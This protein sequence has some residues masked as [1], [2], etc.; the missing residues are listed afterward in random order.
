[1]YNT[2]SSKPSIFAFCPHYG[3]LM[4]MLRG[5]DSVEPEA[6]GLQSTSSIIHRSSTSSLVDLPLG[7]Q[8][9]GQNKSVE[10]PETILFIM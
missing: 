2:I 1:M 5:L 7:T 9:Q 8:R 6:F 3:Q 10:G 4:S